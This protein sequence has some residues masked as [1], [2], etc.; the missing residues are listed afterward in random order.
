MTV[1]ASAQET[2]EEVDDLVVGDA[3]VTRRPDAGLPNPDYKGG[4]HPYV[5]EDGVRSL[6]CR[7]LVLIA[8]LG[9]IEGRFKGLVKIKLCLP[10]LRCVGQVQC[11]ASKPYECGLIS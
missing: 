8:L 3:E 7:M 9:S 10:P 11:R 4:D 2:A 1:T 5:S 6:C